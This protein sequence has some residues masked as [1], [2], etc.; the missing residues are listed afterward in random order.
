MDIN[1][2]IHPIA[3][4]QFDRTGIGTFVRDPIALEAHIT[5][6][7]QDFEFPNNGQGFVALPPE[8][9]NTVVPGV[10]RRTNNPDDYVVRFHRERMGLYLNRDKVKLPELGGLAAIVYTKE[11]YLADPQTSAEEKEAFI[12]AGYTHCWVTTL[13]M[14]GPKAPVD[15]W[16]F[17]VNLAG[18]N[19]KYKE[20]A[21]EA[22][23]SYV[24]PARGFL[25]NVVQA[26]AK[27]VQEYWAEW[28]VVASE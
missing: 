3:K 28:A 25:A 2:F 15:P 8:A 20:L 14:A 23:G 27:E 17:V 7:L 16:R 21:D 18:G 19:A 1:I 4:S 6:A 9:F 12:E 11:A 10:A 24:N 5:S 13:A 22:Q 26:E